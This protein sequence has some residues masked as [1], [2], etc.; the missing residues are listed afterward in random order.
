LACFIFL[1]KA[2]QLLNSHLVSTKPTQDQ[3]GPVVRK[4]VKANLGLILTK[5]PLSLISKEFS[6]QIPSDHLKATKVK[7]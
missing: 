6:Q 5:V 2:L 7:M 1:V 3:L 4:L